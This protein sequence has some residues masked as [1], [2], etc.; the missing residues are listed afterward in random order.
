VNTHARVTVA[1]VPGQRGEVA[2]QV[3]GRER[4]VPAVARRAD[5]RFDVGDRVGIVAFAN[6]TAE[7]VSRQEYEFINEP[8]VGDDT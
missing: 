1:I 2:L 4:F 3:R 7:V 5:D 6:G 8:E